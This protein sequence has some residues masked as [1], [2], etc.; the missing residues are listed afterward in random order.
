[1]ERK[2]YI[3]YLCPECKRKFSSGNYKNFCP[4]CQQKLIFILEEYEK[5]FSRISQQPMQLYHIARAEE[6]IK[7]PGQK[8][9]KGLITTDLNF[10]PYGLLRE[11]DLENI[12][13]GKVKGVL[14][15]PQNFIV[16]ACKIEPLLEE[17]RIL[18][19]R[20]EGDD[21]YLTL[22]MSN[23]Q[24]LVKRV[25]F[26]NDKIDLQQVEP[27]DRVLLMPGTNDIVNAY[28]P[29]I[30]PRFDFKT[31]KDLE[32]ILFT[33]I[34]GLDN[35]KQQVRDL[36]EYLVS[37][38]VIE[39][40]GIKKPVGVLFV[41]F[42]GTG[43][44]MMA[45]ALAFETGAEYIEVNIGDIITKYVGEPEQR[46][47]EIFKYAR[48]RARKNKKGVIVFL[49]ELDA[50]AP[51]REES[52][53]VARRITSV[54]LKEMDEI[55]KSGDNVIVIGATN[56]PEDLDPALLRPGRFD[57]II[58][59]PLPDYTAR[60]EILKIYTTQNRKGRKSS[61][62]SEDVDL[63]YLA[64]ITHGYTGADLA[65]L[66]KKAGY[67]AFRENKDK[68][69]RT[70]KNI[71]IRMEHFE[72]AFKQITPTILRM[73]RDYSVE[74]PRVKFNDVGGLEKTKQELYNLIIFPIKYPEVAKSLKMEENVGILIYGPPGV[75]KTL[76]AKAV[77]GEAG[78]YVLWIK[79]PQLYN[80]FVGEGE[81]AVRK[82]FR[83]AR[84]L[85]KC[86]IIIYE[87][88]SLLPAR[89]TR[90]DSG[91]SHSLVSQFLAEMDGLRNN[92]GIY[93]I[94]TTNR[95]DLIDPAVLRP[96]RIGKSIEIGYPNK[97]ER[98]EIYRIHTR[99]LPLSEDVDLD[100]LASM[101]GYTG[102]DIAEICSI[103]KNELIREI[104]SEFEKGKITEK[105]MNDA[106][107]IKKHYKLSMKHFDAAI[108]VFE[109]KRRK[110]EAGR[111]ESGLVF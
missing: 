30:T 100:K 78:I 97:M 8:E 88:D 28:K 75:G 92:P 34:G 7:L 1:M 48:E 108:R 66:Y 12:K 68:S 24:R 38:D 65:L 71:E 49:D 25:D 80:K 58:E 53:E 63:E 45:R 111:R 106:E 79:G 69:L 64:R 31:K 67:I 33:D 83:L 70:K 55:D 50:L 2:S 11:E 4:E 29:E 96:G 26:A 37:S 73:L 39:K 98:L 61:T 101:E 103:A 9:I 22:E 84:L 102:A 105:E 77:A 60:L 18:S 85:G 57:E 52:S 91:A 44:T 94:G 86:I 17:A 40:M 46:I 109:E 81:K 5:V 41:G 10:F 104:R 51:Q 99:D 72:K 74:I 54:L 87:I 13:S 16:G 20:K 110:Y 3:N 47:R 95:P 6:S 89:G 76:L 35:I 19:K 14:V 93:V 23:G 36:G 90:Y 62:L 56:M 82:L 21:V 15:S 27:G 107:F 42:P 59:F 43:K 32:K